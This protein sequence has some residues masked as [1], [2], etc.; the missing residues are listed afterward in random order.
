MPVAG[1]GPPYSVESRAPMSRVAPSTGRA[2]PATAVVARHAPG[3]D[4]TGAERPETSRVDG[5]AGRGHGVDTSQLGN[6][7]QSSVDASGPR[8]RPAPAVPRSASRPVVGRRAA[9]RDRVVRA[10]HPVRLQH[11]DRRADQEHSLRAG[12]VRSTSDEIGA[13]A[14]KAG[15]DEPTTEALVDDYESAQPR[16][17]RQ[18]CWQR[19]PWPSLLD[20]HQGSAAS[21]C[22]G[23]SRTPT[24]LKP[25]ARLTQ[26]GRPLTHRSAHEPAEE[27]DI[28]LQ[29][30]VPEEALIHGLAPGIAQGRAQ[31]RVAEQHRQRVAES[32]ARRLDHEAV[33]RRPCR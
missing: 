25:E 20:L 19:L 17:S 32:P 2:G 1:R 29:V 31:L 14:R 6:V 28:R 15:V 18:G 16:R 21:G 33:L 7:V 9:L 5:G 13:A 12:R 10:H 3:D 26:A 8:C 11:H 23:R 24:G 27:V 4:R 22:P 30:A